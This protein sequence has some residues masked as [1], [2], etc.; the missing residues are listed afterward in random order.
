MRATIATQAADTLPVLGIRQG[1]SCGGMASELPDA[2]HAA[3]GEAIERYSACHAPPS[4][5]RRATI[6]QLD[7]RLPVVPPDWGSGVPPDAHSRPL[8]WLRGSR[9]GTG[10]GDTSP[11][12]LPA[13]RVFLDGTDLEDG[14]ATGTSTG[15]A[16]HVDPWRACGPACSR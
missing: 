12:W 8:H 15:L 4:R 16:C 7:G 5:L 3:V 1:G 2:Q 13:H 9:L 10:P 14:V 11:A 6:P